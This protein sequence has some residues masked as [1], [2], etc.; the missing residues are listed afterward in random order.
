M[1]QSKSVVDDELWESMTVAQHG[2][3]DRNGRV[4]IHTPEPTQPRIARTA[5]SSSASRRNAPVYEKVAR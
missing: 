3:D 1:C 2:V 4:A 5:A